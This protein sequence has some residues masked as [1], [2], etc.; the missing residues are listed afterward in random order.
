[1][2]ESAHTC[3]YIVLL[4][5]RF[6]FGWTET[7]GYCTSGPDDEDGENVVARTA[8]LVIW[9][10]GMCSWNIAGACAIAGAGGGW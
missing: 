3:L 4:T 7:T 10:G 5:I 1:M 8:L 2:S 9:D 6:F